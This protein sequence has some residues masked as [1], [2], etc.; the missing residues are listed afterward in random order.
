[1]RR[2]KQFFS[3]PFPAPLSPCPFLKQCKTIDFIAI[4]FL[5]HFSFSLRLKRISTVI[6]RGFYGYTYLFFIREIISLLAEVDYLSLEKFLFHFM[7]NLDYRRDK[8]CCKNGVEDEKVFKS[9]L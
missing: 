3:W 2:E 6:E 5:N 4:Y 1:M 8:I 9:D 7:L